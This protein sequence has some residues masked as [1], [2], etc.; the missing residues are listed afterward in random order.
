MKE[1]ADSTTPKPKVVN[2]IEVRDVKS[3]VSPC[4]E[5]LHGHTDPHCFKFVEVAGDDV[6]M[7][8]KRWSS[9]PWCDD[10]D[11]LSTLKVCRKI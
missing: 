7:Y 3:W 1:T 4:L 10:D 2:L 8:F 11:A 6:R 9:D 5:S